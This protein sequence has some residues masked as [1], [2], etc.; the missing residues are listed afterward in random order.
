MGGRESFRGGEDGPGRGS[1]SGE[2]LRRFAILAMVAGGAFP[3]S[4]GGCCYCREGVEREADGE[5]MLTRERN[6]EVEV[7]R[8]DWKARQ[9][10]TS[11]SRLTRGSK[12]IARHANA[13]A[14]LSWPLLKTSYLVSGVPSSHHTNAFQHFDSWS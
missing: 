3:G 10:M 12:E 2:G 8:L 6:A 7:R 11:T 5:V 4:G 9:T 13:R 14:P 1:A